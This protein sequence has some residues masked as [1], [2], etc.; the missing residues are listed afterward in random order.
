MK[1]HMRTLERNVGNFQV[2]F[3]LPQISQKSEKTLLYGRGIQVWRIYLFH[4][5]KFIDN[6]IPK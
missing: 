4:L 2:K 1:I 3:P 5:L 6:W